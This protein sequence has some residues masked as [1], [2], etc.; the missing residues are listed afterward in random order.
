MGKVPLIALTATAT[1]S[2]RLQ[3]MRSLEM[4]KPILLIESPNRHNITYAVKVITPNPAKTFQTMVQDLKEQKGDYD[5]TIVYCQSIEVATQLYGSFQAELGKDIYLDETLD[6]RKR[7]VEMFHSRIDELNREEILKSM[8]MSGGS[9]RVLIATIAYG[10]GIDC[11]DV[12]VVIHYGP[13]Y[14]LETYMQE[15]G[16]AGRAS[17]EVCK[18]VLLYSSLMMKYCRDDIKA[19]ARDCSQCRRKILLS[20]F[21]SDVSNLPEPEHAHECCDICQRNCKCQGT[22]CDFVYFDLSSE[23][24]ELQ[25]HCIVRSRSVTDFE[26]EGLSK[27][28]QYLKIALSEQYIKAV[29][30]VNIP[31]FTPTKFHCTFGEAQVQQILVHC[32]HIFSIIDILKFVDIWHVNVA[33]EVLFVFSQVFGDVD[34]TNSEDEQDC[35]DTLDFAHLNDDILDFEIEDSVLADI[36]REFFSI[37]ED[38]LSHHGEES[39]SDVE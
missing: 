32:E 38:T 26:K 10:M 5:R 33:E 11:K 15:S 25:D 21:D 31:M 29:R 19:Y 27:K 23:V 17:T 8:G 14:N 24:N 12:K 30:K 39:D 1:T 28:L 4:K 34:V 13:S 3:I 6:P 35:E 37:V 2:T 22:S 16:R 7:I 36:P 9:I 20:H 18:S